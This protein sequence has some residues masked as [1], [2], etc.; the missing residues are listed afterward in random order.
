METAGVGLTTLPSTLSEY[1]LNKT[2]FLQ[3]GLDI[4]ELY[5]DKEYFERLLKIALPIILQNFITSFLNMVGVILIGQLG[6]TPV[7]AVGLA[8]QIFFLLNLLLFGITSGAAIF[9]AQLWGK[10]DIA[11]IRKVLGLS[12]LLCLFAALVFLTISELSPEWAL[13]IYSKDPAVVTEGSQY[14]RVFGWSFA[15]MAVTYSYS[16]V[17]RSI[18][19]VKTPLIVSTAALALN[20]GLSYGLILGKLGLPR[21]GVYGAGLSVLISRILECIALLWITYRRKSPAAVRLREILDVHPSFIMSVLRPVIPVALNELFWALGVT[22][23]NVVYARIGTDSIAAMNIA[24]SIDNLALVTFI[25]IANACAILV[26]N[27]IGAGQQHHAFRYAARS[28]G[29]G[30]VGS[31]IV[32]GIIL[33]GSD[34]VL[35]QYK[36]SP[37]VIEYA[38]KVLM[39]IAFFLWL[40]VSNLMLFVGIFRS[41]GD[42]RFAFILDAGMIWAVGVPMALLG[43]FVL[44]L[45]VYLVYLMVMADEF[46]K[47]VIGMFRFFS[48]RWIH[49]LAQIV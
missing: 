19:D 29:L 16:A 12:L 31:I 9:T 49:D 13:G 43:A 3:R 28:L 45:P 38:H 32:G 15:F 24:F 42:T 47:W 30:V 35:M 1:E 36:V 5:R 20:I 18:G 48:K 39:V 37:I 2:T 46:T 25:G 17:L 7:A 21:L 11:N 40:R 41:G 33:I 22:T 26:G 4:V 10:H 27:Q 14:L 44:G 8:G 6:E 23:Y 34:I